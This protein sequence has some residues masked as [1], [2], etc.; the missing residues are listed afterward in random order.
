MNH[1]VREGAVSN[2]FDYTPARRLEGFVLDPARCTARELGLATSGTSRVAILALPSGTFLARTQ[3]GDFDD[4]TIRTI[5]HGAGQLYLDVSSG[6]DLA[7]FARDVRQLVVSRACA[8]CPDLATCCAAYEPAPRSF[9]AGD[10][11]RLRDELRVLRGR[12]LDVGAGRMPY[13]DALDDA[14][15]AGTVEYFALDPDPD[16]EAA[17]RAEGSPIR[18]LAGEVEDLPADVAPLDGAFAIRSLNHFRDLDAAFARLA[19]VLRPGA[20]LLL[21]ESLALPLVR[22]RRHAERAHREAVGGFQHV[23]NASSTDVLALV[24]GRFPFAV[25]WHRPVAR[26]TCDQWFL[27]LR[28][29]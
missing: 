17:A 1:P 6:T 19:A 29:L 25:E 21:V 23:R 18:F 4:A 5:V 24:E 15:R 7:D 14:I 10:E 22:G 27:R 28:R 2:S 26:D 20:P 12:L 3:T 8:A 13:R 9:F 16:V 11:A